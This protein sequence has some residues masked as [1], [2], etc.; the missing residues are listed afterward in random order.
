M[1]RTR[2]TSLFAFLVIVVL[3]LGY[4][5]A[6]GNK[7][8]LGLDLQGGVS[9]VL[10]PKGNPP[11]QN[12]EQAKKI[13]RS[14]VDALGVAEP[15]IVRQG[16]TIVVQLPGVKDR[17]KALSVIGQT[18]RLEFRP[19]LQ[20]LGTASTPTTTP[21]PTAPTAPNVS[22]PTTSAS[23]PGSSG[24]APTQ[25]A[26]ATLL[27]PSSAPQLGPSTTVASSNASDGTN[28]QQSLGGPGEGESAAGAQAPGTTAPSTPS[29]SPAP[30]SPAPT[31]APQAAPSA[32][33]PSAPSAPG[34]PGAGPGDASTPVCSSSS[35]QAKPCIGTSRQKAQG[36]LLL[37]PVQA[38]GTAVS[39]AQ[40]AVD[41]A[42]GGSNWLVNISIKGSLKG[43]INALFNACYAGDQTCPATGTDTK[44]NQPRGRAAIVLDGVV[45]SA[46]TVD[47]QNLA[48]GSFQISGGFTKAEATDLALVLRYGALPVEFKKDVNVQE[49]S[50]TLG[51]DYLHAGLVAGFVGLG[52]VALYMVGFYR[53]L[54][55]VAIFSLATGAALLWT[56]IA[57]LGQ[58]RGL[59]L[60]LAGITGIIV[61]I[62]VAV[63]SNVVFYEHLREDMSKG[64]SLRS[65]VNGS[66]DS[67]WRTI[68]SADLVSLI[69]AGLLYWLT[70]GSVRGFAFY[71]GLSTILDLVASYLF[72][73]PLVLWIGRHDWFQ[74]RPR[75]LGVRGRPGP[76]DL[77]AAAATTTGAG[78][79][80]AAAAVRARPSKSGKGSRGVAV[81]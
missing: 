2:L 80:P 5:F 42:T 6:S 30:T 22:V 44:T 73:R 62:G 58:T 57:Y 10:Q 55:V 28:T 78:R 15:D 40:A 61:S 53:L 7:P 26:P 72:M 9:V 41:Q 70:V 4:T 59:A 25:V 16:H 21:A 77:A 45:Q 49:V 43:K 81:R 69:G 24:A 75:L 20:S 27:A 32:A 14:R 39:S 76:A 3:A 17:Q 37:G 47:G 12:V 11:D 1:K 48:D 54:G 36:K 31:G 65:T 51:K 63:D 33:A 8:L 67:A 60:T 66:F 46:P 79:E 56:V 50:A 34:V 71:L 38:P 29:T 19:V 23:P 13:I 74:D 68:V 52:L 64:R 35:D 18:A